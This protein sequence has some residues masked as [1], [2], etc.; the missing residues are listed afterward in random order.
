MLGGLGNIP[1]AMIGGLLLGLI[2]SYG[3][4]AFGGSYRN[5]FAFVILILVL[6]FRPN[7]IFS[8]KRQAPP[9]PL[10]GTFIPNNKPVRVPKWLIIGLGVV[11]GLLPLLVVTRYLLQIL[12]NAW[13]LGMVALSVTLVTG[14]AGQTSLGQAGFLAIGAYASALLTLRLHWPFELSLIAAGLF[15]A[16]LGTLLVL[17]AFRCGPIMSPLPRWASAKSSARSS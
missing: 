8:R 7:G 14:T 3:V 9:E 16:L 10:T 15:T 6:V 11:A 5:L 2:E 13:L 1:G 4:S 17:P 12:T